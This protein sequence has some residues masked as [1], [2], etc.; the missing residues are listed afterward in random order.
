MPPL[1]NTIELHAD[2]FASIGTV[3]SLDFAS[4]AL[5]FARPKCCTSVLRTMR[6]SRYLP[7][8]FATRRSRYRGCVISRFRR[9][10]SSRARPFDA[11]S[12]LQ[13][14]AYE[15]GKP[16]GRKFIT[17]EQQ[18]ITLKADF[19]EQLRGRKRVHGTTL[20]FSC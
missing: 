8:L 20:W 18:V 13:R 16:A 1:I 17:R 9:F 19:S 3:P 2:H 11:A 15:K 12:L 14:T 10:F 6:P 5:P 4:V 7:P